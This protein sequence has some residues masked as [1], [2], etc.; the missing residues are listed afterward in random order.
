MEVDL[1]NGWAPRDY[2]LAAWRYLQGGGRHA[3]LV[4]HRRAGKDE[5]GLHHTACA[6]FKRTA[7]YWHMLPLATQARKAIWNAIN[8]HTGKKR[9]DEAFPHALRKATRS[10]EMQ[11]EFVNGSIWQVVG[12]D[13]FNS[14]VGS[15]PAGIVYSEWALANPS[16]RAYLRPIL[17]ENGGWQIFIGT[18]RGKNHAYRTYLAAKSDPNAFAQVL[19]AH[20]TGIFTPDA[21]EAERL[22]YCADFGEEMG[23]ALFDQEYG[24]SFDAAILGA[25]LGRWMTK[26]RAQGR[27]REEGV[28]DPDGGLVHIS[29]DIGFH[30]TS[31]WWF[32]QP[33]HGGFGVVGYEGASGR[34][35]DDWIDYL[36]AYI[37]RRGF[38]LGIIWLPHDARNK[39]FAAKHSPL[40]RF[41]SAFG[42]DHVAI[43]PQTKIEHRINAARRVIGRCWFDE[44]ECA[45][46]IDGL[47]SW[48]YKYN[49]ETKTFSKEP[50]HN[51]ASH[52]GDAFSYGAEML[53][54]LYPPASAQ[55]PQF[56][57]SA[58]PNGGF[59]LAPLETLWKSATPRGPERI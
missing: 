55:A 58:G 47:T 50:E 2:Q 10:Q 14:L 44:P 37:A 8:P 40:E 16:A 7:N 3:E 27:L 38:K 12:S 21:L 23:Q 22:S 57:V 54:E 26:A 1:P 5:I 52:P 17:M 59:V 6:A 33:R 56:P 48:A 41:L 43:V 30:D 51:W 20:D 18:P 39:T 34:D 24:C 35:A 53:E 19:S 36:R 11:I 31:S 9:I 4:W 45:D 15:P 46:G 49:D 42:A 29:S 32:W 25:V 13:N 28:F